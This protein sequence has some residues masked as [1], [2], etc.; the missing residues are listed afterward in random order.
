MPPEVD[1]SLVYLLRGQYVI[2]CPRQDCVGAETIRAQVTERTNNPD[3]DVSRALH[4]FVSFGIHAPLH[5]V[6]L[7]VLHK[8]GADWMTAYWIGVFVGIGLIASGVS[9]WLRAVFG[10]G[11]AGVASLMVGTTYFVGHGFLWIVPSNV[12]IGLG[13][14]TAGLAVQLGRKASL[15]VAA[16]LWVVVFMHLTGRGIAAIVVLT[17]LASTGPPWSRRDWY[18]VCSGVAAMAIYTA[19]PFIFERPDF[20]IPFGTE[21][22]VGNPLGVIILNVVETLRVTL[23][24]TLIAG[25]FVPMLAAAVVAYF[26]LPA[27]RRRPMAAM[28]LAAGGLCIVSLFHISPR[29]PAELFARFWIFLAV[30]M[31][32]SAA[33]V[34]WR[35]IPLISLERGDLRALWRDPLWD[36]TR[37]LSPRG[38]R[39]VGVLALTV[40]AAGALVHVLAGLYFIERARVMMTVRHDFAFERQQPALMLADRCGTIYYSGAEVLHAYWLYGGLR[41]R[42]IIDIGLDRAAL[43]RTTDVSHAVVFNRMAQFQ[44]WHPLRAGEIFT[45]RSSAESGPGCSVAVET[46]ASVVAHLR[47]AKVRA[48]MTIRRGGAER[49]VTIDTTPQWI[50]LGPLGLADSGI[51]LRTEVG[52]VAIGG[53]RRSQPGMLNWPWDQG[54]TIDFIRDI[55]H[56]SRRHIEERFRTMNHFPFGRCVEVMDDRGFTVLARVGRPS[57]GG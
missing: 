39:L 49:R 43:A 36:S 52:V 21:G 2:E 23:R 27:E 37:L 8:V 9:L 53:L 12:A 31:T 29:I 26:I 28:L 44:N 56:Q 55:P 30:T 34:L 38:W 4:R 22:F 17:Y 24:T 7:A 35:A 33:L 13:F 54:L 25:G 32:G 42:S 1:D 40:L 15:W 20:R 19:L 10:E 6:F 3:I 57:A 14:L 18:P 16:L 51:V 47:A 48:I 41:C 45:I 46:S 5:A 50:D 11:A